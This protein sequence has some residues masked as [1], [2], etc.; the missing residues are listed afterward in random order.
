MSHEP[1]HD[2][3]GLA[4]TIIKLAYVCLNRGSEFPSDAGARARR[5]EAARDQV[6]VPPGLPVRIR[7]YQSCV[8]LGHASRQTFSSLTES[9][10]RDNRDEVRVFVVE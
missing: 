7:E 8:L 10:E 4:V 5:M 3:Y 1:R 9:R 2:D 6:R